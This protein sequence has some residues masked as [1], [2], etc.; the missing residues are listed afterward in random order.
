VTKVPFQRPQMPP[1]EL[2]ESYF[3]LSRESHWYSNEGPCARLLSERLGAYVGAPA[4][5]APVSSGTL[6]LMVAL[7]AAVGPRP[8]RTEVVVPSFTYIATVSAILWTGLQP[9]FV[10]VSPEHWHLDPPALAQALEER[11]DAVA[12][13]LAC[14]TFGT[15]PPAAVTA[16]WEAACE[17]AGVPLVVDSA[18]GF[19]S[20][21]ERDRP[22][23]L[24]GLAE[25]FSFHATKPFAIGEGGAVST[26]DAELAGAVK[27][28]AT[29]GLGE[30][31]TLVGE[32]GL[33]AKMS[34]LH[35]ATALAQLDCFSDVL[36][37]RRARAAAIRAGL[38]GHGFAF[39]PGCESS[40]SQFVA[41]LAPDADSAARV[42]DRAAHAEIQLRSYHQPLHLQ[43]TLRGAPVAGGL[44]VT[45]D[46]ARRSLSVP[47]ANDLD[48]EEIAR[49]RALL[50][51][52]G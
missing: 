40:A 19:G 24:Q 33:N 41:L 29:F 27:R 28:Q 38:D 12:A 16:G 1:R 52:D 37:S 30:D 47:L 10:D 17:T 20:R 32:P 45:L 51:A 46:L 21:D 50:L 44:E 18:A 48:D 3:E 49:I 35:A 2:V 6:G 22:L 43:A 13:V 26:A 9:V 7:R 25:V 8:A 23:G 36:A 42:L 5:C 34:E 14:S 4:C 15:A 39:Q 31:R 11:S